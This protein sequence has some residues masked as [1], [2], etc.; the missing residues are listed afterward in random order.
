[1]D[2]PFLAPTKMHGSHVVDAL[3]SDGGFIEDADIDTA[4]IG[5]R[6]RVGRGAQIRRSLLLGADFYDAADATDPLL[7]IGEGSIIQDAI[8]DKNA[9][10][11][12]GVRIT[13]AAQRREYDGGSYYIR[14]GIVVVPKNGVIP[15]HTVI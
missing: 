6:M 1:M 10:V 2:R 14:E 7:G 4:V 13:N 8:I 11:G 3:I 9:R 15:D 12:R 5:P